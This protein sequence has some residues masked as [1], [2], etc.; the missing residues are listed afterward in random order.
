MLP[1]FTDVFLLRRVFIRLLFG[2]RV[3]PALW[4]LLGHNT[5]CCSMFLCYTTGATVT[6][7][8]DNED[9]DCVVNFN[10]VSLLCAP[11]L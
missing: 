3:E 1:R 11:F 6:A 2:P 4:F 5:G 9:H 7:A 8:Q 10:Q